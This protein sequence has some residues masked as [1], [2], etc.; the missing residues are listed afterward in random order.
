PFQIAWIAALAI[1]TRDPLPQMD[2]WLASLVDDNTPL[3]S[4]V[5]PSP[6]LGAS[7]AALLLSRRGVSTRA[8]GLELVAQPIADRFRFAPFRFLSAKDHE[9]VRRW[10]DK[11][12]EKDAGG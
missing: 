1:A 8:F 11:Q 7:A 3:V 4:N 6:E 9:E 2:A 10:W 12:K 5:D